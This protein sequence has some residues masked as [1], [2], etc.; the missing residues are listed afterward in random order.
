MKTLVLTNHHGKPPPIKM[1]NFS[2]AATEQIQEAFLRGVKEDE[3]KIRL[4]MEFGEN[5]Y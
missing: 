1:D 4:K 2:V 3:E 5:E